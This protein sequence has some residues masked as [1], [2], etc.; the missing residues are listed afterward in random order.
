MTQPSSRLYQKAIAASQAGNWLK[1]VDVLKHLRAQDPAFLPAYYE[2]V[3]IYLQ[4]GYV[5]LAKETI[6]QALSMAPQDANSLLILADIHLSLAEVDPAL[7]LYQELEKKSDLPSSDLL[8]HLALA[9]SMK[10]EW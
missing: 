7:I 1:A 10:R 2:L 6:E 8:L 4:R 3:Q 5:S 9:Y